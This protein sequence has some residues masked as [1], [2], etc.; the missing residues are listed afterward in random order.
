[1]VAEET[2]VPQRSIRVSLCVLALLGNGMVV[3]AEDSAADAVEVVV[4]LGLASVAEAFAAQEVWVAA[5]VVTKGVASVGAMDFWVGK[6]A[7]S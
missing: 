6:G 1:M 3:L 5:G 2:A 4:V 7:S